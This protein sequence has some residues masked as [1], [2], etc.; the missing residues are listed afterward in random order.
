MTTPLGDLLSP[1]SP[2]MSPSSLSFASRWV[3]TRRKARFKSGQAPIS[4]SRLPPAWASASREENGVEACSRSALSNLPR[5]SG[6]LQRRNRL[7]R[8]FEFLLG[9]VQII[10]LLQ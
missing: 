8:L 1:P 10:P 7:D 3:C 4:A 9:V 5:L 6:H 2:L